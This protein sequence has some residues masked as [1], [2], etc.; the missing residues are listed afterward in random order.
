MSNPTDVKHLSR[1]LALRKFAEIASNVSSR[2]GPNLVFL[3]E[4][5]DDSK[6][7]E[8]TRSFS[9]GVQTLNQSWADLCS[10]VVV[11][12]GRGN[13]GK[14][15]FL[16][17]IQ[18]GI[19]ENNEHVIVVDVS[20]DDPPRK[21]YQQHIACISGLR[22]AE[23]TNP[24]KLSEYKKQKLEDA[25]NKFFDWIARGLIIP[26]EALEPLSEGKRL[27]IR[28]YKTLV[29]YM[30]Y[31]RKAYP[32]HKIVMFVDAWNNL[33]FS[34]A[35]PGSEIMQ[36]NQMLDELKVTAE[37]NE[38]VLI[39]SAHIKK[40]KE[41]IL[42]ISDIKGTSDLEYGVV[43]AFLGR[44]EHR[45][46]M[47]RDPLMYEVGDYTLPIFV[48]ETAKTKVSE[49][50]LPLFYALDSSRCQIIVPTPSEYKELL[51]IY[52]GRRT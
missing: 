7:R 1:E 5:E 52:K 11:V 49:W 22:Y 13:S 40:T 26:L 33:D 35:R 30:S 25:K 47:L 34:Q 19:I 46:N 21:R 18:H 43:H 42:N 9:D 41:K 36:T 32:T 24:L 44:N 31:L 20:L 51:E 17:N 16:T 2:S 37:N 50:D 29:F 6:I 28:D 15:T 14:S 4:H 27:K 3:K 23:I 8:L 39:I 48:L 38:I 45:E 10:G 12:G